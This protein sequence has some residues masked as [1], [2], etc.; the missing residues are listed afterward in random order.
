MSPSECTACHELTDEIP[1][2]IG[3][4]LHSVSVSTESAV[5]ANDIGEIS[6]EE[7]VPVNFIPAEVY[8]LFTAWEKSNL[9]TT[10]LSDHMDFDESSEP[11]QL[12]PEPAQYMAP[13]RRYSRTFW[14]S[15]SRRILL[16]S[17][18]QTT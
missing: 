16:A 18:L 5:Q 8:A 11:A 4:N 9:T 2:T 12:M 3:A 13:P 17:S 14:K 15:L 10:S 6:R 7:Y 1:A